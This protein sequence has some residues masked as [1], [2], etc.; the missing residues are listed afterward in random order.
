MFKREPGTLIWRETRPDGQRVVVKLYRRRGLISMLRS[1]ATR[2]RAE[3]EERRLRR[4]SRAGIPC[5]SPLG[6][7]HGYSRAH[8]FHEVLI[9]AEIG[10]A[11]PL[12]RFL[13]SGPEP[14]TLG[15]LYRMVRQMH[16]SGFC[17]QTLYASNVLVVP[18][19]APE[20]RYFLSDVPRSWTFPETIV[21][22]KMATLDLLDLTWTVEQEGIPAE[23]VPLEA[24][25]TPAVAERWWEGDRSLAM[26]R[27]GKARTKG[28]RARRD[29]AVRIR[30][31]IAW[32]LYAVR[33]L[34][35]YP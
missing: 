18:H 28:V 6:W 14:E 23:S 4:L 10:G 2:F 29:I 22:T 26:L 27:A 12:D 16:E 19:S 13:E 9:T 33:F 31:A 20:S 24:Y 32:S 8:G 15:P 1:R 30:W 34:S 35:R 17:H 3:R 25:A 11:V 5:T 7:T 21:G